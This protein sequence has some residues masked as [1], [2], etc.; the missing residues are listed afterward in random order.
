MIHSEYLILVVGMG[1]VTYIPRWFPI[2]FLS[3]RQL[4][5]W[6][7]ASCPNGFPSGWI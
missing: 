6:F 4:P 2:F 3:R 5:Q 7:S 1:L